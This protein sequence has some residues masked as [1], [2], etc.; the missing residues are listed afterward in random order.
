MTR[1]GIRSADLARAGDFY[2]R[3]FGTEIASAAS[4]RSRSFAIGDSTLELISV[5]A[6]SAPA[7]ARGID[8]IRIAVRDFDVE[9]V[10]RILQ[11]RQIAMDGRAPSGS[12]R[13]SDP[14]GIGLELTTPS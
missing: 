8:H 13:I 4:S 14:D 3:L 7:T 1:I 9:S 11:E 12:V 6:A 5:S 2:G 10:K